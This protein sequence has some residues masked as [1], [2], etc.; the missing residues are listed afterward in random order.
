[1]NSMRWMCVAATLLSVPACK[2]EKSVDQPAAAAPSPTEGGDPAAEPGAAQPAEPAA[3]NMAAATAAAGSADA[4]QAEAM[5]QNL[6]AGDDG[7]RDLEKPKK[8]MVAIGSSGKEKVIA[9]GTRTVADTD[10]YTVKLAS[11]AKLATGS[12]GSATLEIVPK[13]GWHL[14][15]E[16]PYKLTVAA[17]AG[18][19]VA[20]PEQGKKDT[21]AFSHGSMKWAIDFEASAAG[22]KAFTGKVKF[23]VCTETSCDPKKEELAFN[24]KVE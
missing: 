14:N 1:M 11:P 18:A 21:V 10:S 23:A 6:T 3:A 19:K 15:D 7:G 9:T 8:D 5:A 24:V 12:K 17:P 20:K 4:E 22:D 2:K 13:K 16:F